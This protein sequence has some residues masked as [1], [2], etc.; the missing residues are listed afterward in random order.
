LLE[1]ETHLQR[2]LGLEYIMAARMLT[3]YLYLTILQSLL[4]V[5]MAE[6]MVMAGIAL[7][8]AQVVL[9]E[10]AIYQDM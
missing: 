10:T 3:H 2:H 1:Q 7:E 6:Q 9:V 5:E 8:V 4:R